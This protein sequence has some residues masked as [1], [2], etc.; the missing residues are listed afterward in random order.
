[1]AVGSKGEV[2]DRLP[3]IH[4]PRHIPMG[5]DGLRCHSHHRQRSRYTSGLNEFMVPLYS[6]TGLLLTPHPPSGEP[7]STPSGQEVKR[8]RKTTRRGSSTKNIQNKEI[9]RRTTSTR[10]CDRGTSE[11][12][13]VLI[14]SNSTTNIL[15]KN[16]R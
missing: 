1:M 13:G 5:L 8:Q 12:Q 4:D 7:P 2:T 3:S 16:S 11:S 14:Y 10:G 9:E 15:K 6:P